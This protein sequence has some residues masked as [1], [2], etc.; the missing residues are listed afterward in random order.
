MALLYLK[1]EVVRKDHG[2]AAEYLKRVNEL[3]PDNVLAKYVKAN[4]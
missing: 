4:L 3:D 1:G 2:K